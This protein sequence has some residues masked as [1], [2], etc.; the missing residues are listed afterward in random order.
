MSEQQ[1]SANLPAPKTFAPSRE[2][3][4]STLGFFFG[5]PGKN[6]ALS[7]Q[8]R[9]VYGVPCSVLACGRL[10]LTVA[11][12]ASVSSVSSVFVTAV[13]E[14]LKVLFVLSNS[15]IRHITALLHTP[16]HTH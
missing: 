10:V 15:H 9:P 13:P 1:L 12:L 4:L 2:D 3:V 14:K 11:S 8:T 6:C 16:V 7:T 5:D